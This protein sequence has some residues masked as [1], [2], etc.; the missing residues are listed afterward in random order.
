MTVLSFAQ[1]SLA[2]MLAGLYFFGQKFGSNPF[3]LLRDSGVLD[4]A[5]ALHLNF[6]VNQAMRPDYLNSIK[7]GNDLNPLLQNYWMVIH[8]PVLFLGFATTIVPF[9][10]AIAGLWVKKA[11]IGLSKRCPGRCFQPLYW[12]WVL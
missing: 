3:M 2:T 9:A 8:P 6:D 12:A 1:F 11:Q 5:P 4:N 10:F 7:D